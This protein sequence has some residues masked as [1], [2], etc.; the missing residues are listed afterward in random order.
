MMIVI[1]RVVVLITKQIEVI[2]RTVFLWYNMTP[3]VE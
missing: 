3:E 1:N 2:Q